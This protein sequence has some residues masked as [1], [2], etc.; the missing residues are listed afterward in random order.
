[1]LS[2]NKHFIFS[3]SHCSSTIFIL[4]SYSLFTQVMLSFVLINVQYLQNVVF[5]FE[6][7]LNGQVYSSSDSNHLIKKNPPSKI[8]HSPYLGDPPPQLNTI[9]KILQILL[10]T[11]IQIRTQQRQAKWVIT[12]YWT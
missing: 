6:K 11:L 5:S 7:G 10:S 3:C 4:I 12:N 2:P 9:W 1:M 8:S